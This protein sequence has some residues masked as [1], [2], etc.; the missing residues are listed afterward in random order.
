MQGIGEKMFSQL[1]S[2]VDL[3]RSSIAEFRKFKSDQERKEI[4]LSI[5][6]AYFLLK[7]CVDDGE[8]LIIEA[9]S[10]PVGK[11]NEMEPTEAIETLKRWDLLLR[12][13]GIRLYNLQGYIFGQHHLAVINP[14]LQDKIS[15]VIGYKMDRAVTLHGIGAG[16]FFRNM[17]PIRE[18]NEEKVRLV[19]LMVGAEEDG[20]MDLV[21]INTEVAALQQSLDEY[22]SI[23]ERLVKDE[24]LLSLS[25]TAREKTLFKEGA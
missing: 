18:S 6:E 10:D 14:K 2:V 17:F 16:L 13:Q 7:D 1:K 4:I 3:I 9:G 23:V 19:A 20:T 15:E 21:K 24:E 5:L 12:K 8:K 22:R 25:K 11:I